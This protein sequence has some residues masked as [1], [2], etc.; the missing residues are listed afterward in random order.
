MYTLE[1]S[2]L[3][4]QKT[5]HFDIENVPHTT[6]TKITIEHLPPKPS[7]TVS[8]ENI[9]NKLESMTSLVNK[10][11]PDCKSEKNIEHLKKIIDSLLNQYSVSELQTVL[12]EM[13]FISESVL[14]EYERKIF[15]GKSLNELLN[16][17]F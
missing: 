5:T 13:Q 17:L 1:N 3:F 8:S 7:P 2:P 12:I 10:F 6:E 16:I 4:N 9:N 14:E 15:K 11:F